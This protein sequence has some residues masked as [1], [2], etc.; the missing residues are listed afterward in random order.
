MEYQVFPFVVLEV[1]VAD[2]MRN[3]PSSLTTFHTLR[4][5]VGEPELLLNVSLIEVNTTREVNMI[6]KS[7]FF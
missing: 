5:K 6:F 2:W 7:A 4:Y 1:T 3:A